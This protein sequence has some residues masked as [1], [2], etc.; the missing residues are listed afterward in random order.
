M[1]A[2]EKIIFNELAARRAVVLPGVGTLAVKRHAAAAD[3]GK[4]KAPVNQVLF[5]AKEAVDAPTLLQLMERMGVAKNDAE[6]AYGQWL[7]GVRNAGDEIGIKGVGLLNGETFAPS[8][9]LEQILNPSRKGVQPQQAPVPA[10]PSTSGPAAPVRRRED[11][12]GNC[13]TNILL[14]IIA[15]LLLAIGGIYVHNSCRHGKQL[16]EAE[17]MESFIKYMTPAPNQELQA[18]MPPTSAQAVPVPV[19]TVSKDAKQTAEPAVKR[20]H[21][22]VGSFATE[23]GAETEATRY[24]RDYPQLTVEKVASPNGRTLVSV[25][26]GDTE[27]EA[28]NAFYRIAAQIDNWD[29]W[30]FEKK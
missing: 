30:V 25:F 23:R 26:Q 20:F 28:Y 13:L 22:I 19:P 12:G 16:S 11:G 24:R 9:E 5:S 29:M 27:R 1:K 10:S 4:M 7:E 6:Q 15:V 21:V 14:G 17:L 3:H 8:H 18:Q 2:I